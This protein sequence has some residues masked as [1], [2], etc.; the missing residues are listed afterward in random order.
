MISDITPL[1]AASFGKKEGIINKC[2]LAQVNISLL[3]R[4]IEKKEA[5]L[6]TYLSEEEREIFCRFAFPKRKYEWLGGRI[7]AKYASILYTFQPTAKKIPPKQWQSI[8]VLQDKHRKP[9]LQ[10]RSDFLNLPDISISHS[11]GLALGLASCY[12]CGVDIQEITG[13]IERVESR[14][15]TQEEKKLLHDCCPAEEDRRK[16]LSILWSAKEAIQ[17]A[18]TLQPLPGFLEISLEKIVK[19]DGYQLEMVFSR[20]KNKH[21]SFHKVLAVLYDSYTLAFTFSE[22]K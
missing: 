1:I 11:Y 14:F 13:A 12:H 18:S 4:Q 2:I 19:E 7:A 20:N 5:L 22:T 17:K 6:N 9:F 3:Q 10:T 16:C 21:K 8:Q 15:V